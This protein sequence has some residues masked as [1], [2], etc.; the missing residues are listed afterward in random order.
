M[1]IA[2]ITKI[3]KHEGRTLQMD[4]LRGVTNSSGRR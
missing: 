1:L 4:T 3:S 2:K